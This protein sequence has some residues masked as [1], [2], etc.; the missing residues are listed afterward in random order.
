[1]FFPAAKGS[2][3]NLDRRY[4]LRLLNRVIGPSC[5]ISNQLQMA[6]PSQ[7]PK[8]ATQDS[9][10]RRGDDPR[11]IAHIETACR[12]GIEHEAAAM[13]LVSIDTISVSGAVALLEHVASI[14]AKDCGAWPDLVDQEDG[15]SHSWHY[16]L[17]ANLAAALTVGVA[18]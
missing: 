1:M 13:A 8:W 12:T 6:A 16:F 17:I 7:Y 9:P 3:E 15:K 5:G 2:N 18:A 11:W 14:E 4:H 10:R